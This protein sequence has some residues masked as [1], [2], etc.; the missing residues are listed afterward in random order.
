MIALHVTGKLPTRQPA[1]GLTNFVSWVCFLWYQFSLLLIVIEV[2]WVTKGQSPELKKE[3]SVPCNTSCFECSNRVE[4]CYIILKLYN[5]VT[6]SRLVSPT[7]PKS[8]FKV[9]YCVACP[10]CRRHSLVTIHTGTQCFLDLRQSPPERQMSPLKKILRIITDTEVEKIIS[11]S[12]VIQWLK[13]L[14]VYAA[15]Q[16]GH[17]GEH[18]GVQSSRETSQVCSWNQNEGR[19]LIDKEINFPHGMKMLWK[20]SIKAIKLLLSDNTVHELLTYVLNCT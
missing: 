13:S 5:L 7:S 6:T 2:W 16:K 20:Y 4:E 3:A 1:S 9:I 19:M 8:P 15:V 14:S 18:K 17:N 11:G 12:K 10:L